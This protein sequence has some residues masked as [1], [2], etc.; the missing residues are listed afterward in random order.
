MGYVCTRKRMRV[1]KRTCVDHVCM[2]VCTRVCVYA[3]MH[4][5]CMRGLRMY[6]CMRISVQ[7]IRRYGKGEGDR[8]GA[9]RRGK[10]TE[11]REEG[12]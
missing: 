11:R 3:C 6:A 4:Y 7:C 2:R 1:Y 9:G 8:E 5:V 12:A 10:E